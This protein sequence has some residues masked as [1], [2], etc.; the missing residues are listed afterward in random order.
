ML[1]ILLLNHR[2]QYID[3][4]KR[5]VLIHQYC[6]S[7]PLYHPDPYPQGVPGNSG[8]MPRAIDTI[9]N[10]IGDRLSAS[11]PLQPLGFNRVVA[12]RSTWHTLHTLHTLHSLHSLHSAHSA[13]W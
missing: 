4:F 3:S 1:F 2:L 5:Y 12:V 13:L 9:F 10:T 11:L 6:F 7:A 8:I